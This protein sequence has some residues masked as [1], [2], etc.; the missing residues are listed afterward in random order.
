MS[1]DYCPFCRNPVHPQAIVCG[2]C[3]AQ[4]GY[5]QKPDGYIYDEQDY[6]RM[7]IS[8]PIGIAV[9]PSALV[10]WMNGFPNVFTDIWL[11]VGVAA[12]FAF[13]SAGAMIGYRRLQQPMT[14]YRRKRNN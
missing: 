14:W 1:Q 6:E 11:Y 3:Q 5:W 9:V 8:L 2:S 4:K 7:G 13:W 12:W 10:L